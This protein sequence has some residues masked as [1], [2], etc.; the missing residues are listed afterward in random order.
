MKIKSF[1][2]T[3][4]LLTILIWSCSESTSPKIG[5]NPEISDVTLNYSMDSK[6]LFFSAKT[7]DP[8]GYE[9][10]KTVVYWM[11]YAETDSSEETEF[12]KGVLL[13][14]GTSGDIT[15]NDKI[16]TKKYD[17]IEEGRYRI[18]AEAFDMND[19][20]SE[21]VN[22]TCWAQENTPP[23]I[24]L[25]TAPTSFEKGDTV[26][27]EVKATDPQGLDDIFFIFF[28][29]ENP[30]GELLDYQ[31]Y[32]RD[33]GMLGDNK[34]ND[35]VFSV[36]IPTNS[37]SKSQGVWTFYFQAR[38]KAANLSNQLSKEISNP[39]TAVL[40]PDGG[41][42]FT[43]GET[44][45]LQW[46]SALVDSITIEYTTNG[47]D[48]NPEY[49]HIVDLAGHIKEYDWVVPEVE[50]TYC[51]IRISDK[52]VTSRYDVSDNYFEVK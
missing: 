5:K 25:Q 12:D 23:V 20:V 34:A 36:K 8:Q 31:D 38:D 52:K 15:A 51:K 29:I 14:D 43:A 35:G 49:T 46:A 26:F 33:D 47:N 50:S 42:S 3:L 19:N 24:Y 48:D 6:S 39:G 11:Y 37:S 2:L 45:K 30:D 21:V 22:D 40:Y 27:F 18:V 28:N 10:V 17:D 16:F 1:L 4:S 41:E 32:L 7:D 13:D 9:D 44:I